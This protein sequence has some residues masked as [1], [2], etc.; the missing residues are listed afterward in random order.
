MYKSNV[1]RLRQWLGRDESTVM[2][3]LGLEEIISEGRLKK[4]EGLPPK[5]GPGRP[6]KKVEN[7]TVSTT[8]KTSTRGK[9]KKVSP[10][11]DKKHGKG[12]EKTI[13]PPEKAVLDVGL[14]KGGGVEG[15]RRSPR[16]L[17]KTAVT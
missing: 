16:L 5:R 7:P 6:R 1:A 12:V 14:K 17:G 2:Y 15:L 4:L 9:P 10:V 11:E 8:V 13:V 3:G